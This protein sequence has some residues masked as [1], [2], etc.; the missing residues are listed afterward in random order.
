MELSF[1]EYGIDKWIGM[2][3]MK[4]KK[5]RM[6]KRKKKWQEVEENEMQWRESRRGGGVKSRNRARTDVIKLVLSI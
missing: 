2:E 6:E 3:T 5:K 4:K 1:I